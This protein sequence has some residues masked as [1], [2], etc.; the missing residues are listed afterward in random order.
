MN[1]G[2]SIVMPCYII[3]EENLEHFNKCFKTLK[4]TLKNNKISYEVIVVDNGSNFG[5]KEMKK[6]DVYLRFDEPLGFTKALNKGIKKAKGKYIC[7]VNNDIVFSEDNWIDTLIRDLEIGEL[8]AVY[9]LCQEIEKYYGEIPF[10]SYGLAIDKT[11]GGLWIISKET[12]DKI[13]LFDE[14]NFNW[15]YSDNDFWIRMKQAG[16]RFAVSKNVNITHTNNGRNTYRKMDFT[17]FPGEKTRL[18][19]KGISTPDVVEIIKEEK[20][21]MNEKHGVSQIKE[22]LKQ[23]INKIMNKI[24]ITGGC[25]FVGSHIVEHFLKETDWE[26]IILDRLSYASQGFDR[27]KDI[28]CFD[29]KRVKV[30]TIDLNKPLSEGVKK[31]IGEVD[32]IINLASESHVD[33]SI[34]DPV[35]FVKNNVNLVLNILE[36]ARE[37]KGLKKFI[38]F[39]T[40]EVYGTAPQGVNYK[41]GDRWNPGNPY[42]ASK[43]S[44]DAICMAYSNTFRLPINITNSMNIFGERQHPEKFIPLCIRKILNGEKITIHASPSLMESGTRFYLH[45]RNIAQAI[46]YILIHTDEKLDKEKANLGKW[47]IVGEKEISNLNLAQMIG[48]ILKKEC[49]YEM[50]NFHESRPGHDLRYALDG[51]KLKQAGFDYPKSLEESLEKTV[52]WYLNNKKW[53]G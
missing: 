9:P 5:Q 31:E 52:N 49:K 29:E 45:A 51:S 26:I 50:V 32:Y 24:V 17:H 2:V 13:G 37:Q 39:S 28:E 38:Q 41:E 44:Q 6:A 36:W 30:F 7:Q 25:G 12:F 48:H 22:W 10:N 35:N 47:N 23:N 33:N 19:D 3:D 40:D 42:S 34:T 1:K 15:R 11:F 53:L 14:E 20:R 21:L 8:N 46:H 27:L 4:K 18:R 43:A 16:M